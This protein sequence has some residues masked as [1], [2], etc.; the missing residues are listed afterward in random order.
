MIPRIYNCPNVILVC[1]LKKE[2]YI[3]KWWKRGIIN[4]KAIMQHINEFLGDKYDF[5]VEI[6]PMEFKVIFSR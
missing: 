5:R 2:Y 3:E 1:W 6:T 4:M